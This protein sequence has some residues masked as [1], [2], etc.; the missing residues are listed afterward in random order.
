MRISVFWEGAV[1]LHKNELW[2]FEYAWPV[3]KV[4]LLEEVALLE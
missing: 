4:A 2:L 3:W 1:K